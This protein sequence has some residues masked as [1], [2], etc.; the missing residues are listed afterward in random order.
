MAVNKRDLEL[1]LNSIIYEEDIQ[2][3]KSNVSQA[4][5]AWDMQEY[6]AAD[7]TDLLDMLKEANQKVG[8]FEDIDWEG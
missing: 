2:V 1:L 5:L 4:L 6:V 3:I 8:N 7:G